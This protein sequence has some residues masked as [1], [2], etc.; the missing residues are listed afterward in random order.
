[1]DMSELWNNS[2]KPKEIDVRAVK[3]DL[4]IEI[5]GIMYL[6]QTTDGFNNVVCFR[7]NKKSDVTTLASFH[8]FRLWAVARDIQ[9][10]RVEG[11]ER[12]Y[13]FL[14]NIDCIS[15]RRDPSSPEGR[16]VFYVRLV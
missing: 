14:K 4:C 15:V 16:N 2:I 7:V 6:I 8:M 3:G 13:N 10:I 12:R 5:G 11:S 9:Y 1:M